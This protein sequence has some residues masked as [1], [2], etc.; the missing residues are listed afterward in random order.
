[1]SNLTLT[2]K[3]TKYTNPMQTNLKIILLYCLTMIGCV[4]LPPTSNLQ[5][6]KAQ[7]PIAQTVVVERTTVPELS[8]TYKKA[9]EDN[10]TMNLKN[11]LVKGNYFDKTYLFTEKDAELKNYQSFQF[12]FSKYSHERTPY[13]WYFPLAFIT[14]TF[15]IWFGGTIVIDET[16]YICTLGVRDEKNKIVYQ[17]QKEQKGE[18]DINFYS[19]ESYFPSGA[20]T[21]TKLVMELMEEYKKQRKTK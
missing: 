5:E 20:E 1:M 14:L 18:K 17:I 11:F 9:T 15:Y 16:H 8:D 19:S 3:Y 2:V 13:A 6:P 7:S 10:L 12:H 4:S 21:R